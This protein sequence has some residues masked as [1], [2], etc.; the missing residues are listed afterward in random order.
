MAHFAELDNNNCV[1]RIIVIDNKDTS[2]ANGV[3]D[4]SIGIAF[5][6]S[7]FG[8]DTKWIQVSYNGNIRGIYPGEG[9]LYDTENDIFIPAPRGVIDKSLESEIIDVEEVTPTPTL[10]APT[11]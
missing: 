1:L 9:D 2:D 8:V 3:E 10:E 6:K 11:E 5:C 7:L 4:E